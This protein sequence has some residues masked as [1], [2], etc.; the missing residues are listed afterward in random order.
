MVRR[1]GSLKRIELPKLKRIKRIT[2]GCK[3]KVG[4]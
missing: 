1:F 4:N 3:S 2:H